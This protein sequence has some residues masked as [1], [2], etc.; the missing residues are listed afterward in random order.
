MKLPELPAGK[1]SRVGA[2]LELARPRQYV[3]NGLLWLPLFF[4]HKLLVLEAVKPTMVAFLVFCLAAS[5]VYACNDLLDVAEDR[6]HPLKSRRPLARGALSP[7][8]AA[9]WGLMLLAL[10]LSLA[11]TLLPRE[12]LLWLGAYLALNLAYAIL[13]KH[14]ALLDIVCIALGF[15]LR[16]MAGGV[17]AAVPVSHWLVIMTFLLALFLALGKRRDDLLLAAAG[18]NP[19]RSTGGYSLEFIST[20]MAV[21]AAVTIVAYLL[22]TL[23]AETIARHGGRQLYLTSFWVVLGF[24]RF[25]Q[26]TLVQQQSAS[27]TLALWRDGFLK[28]VVLGWLVHW[29]LVLYVGG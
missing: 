5:S 11:G 10:S 14:F 19:R 3:K 12:F 13:L 20:A 2:Y 26:L 21:M 6:H 24:L 18:T 15:V 1:L 16:V 7:R 27:P 23:S 29:Y 25:L 8:Q 28:T 4:G 9:G 17:A 22:Y